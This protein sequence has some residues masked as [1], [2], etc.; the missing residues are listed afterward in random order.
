M[1]TLGFLQT[2]FGRQWLKNPISETS[3]ILES[4]AVPKV[5]GEDLEATWKAFPGLGVQHAFAS[6]HSVS[7]L[8][9][10]WLARARPLVSLKSHVGLVPYLTKAC[11]RGERDH[12][13]PE[14]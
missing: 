1:Q 6:L 2:V 14:P 5:V 9:L 3:T 13:V 11:V 10:G 4:R 8:W 12:P 7:L